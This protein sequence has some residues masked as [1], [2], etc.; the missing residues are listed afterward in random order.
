MI[1]A[2]ETIYSGYRFRSRLEARWAVFFDTMGFTYEYEKEG[3]DLDGTWY[4]PDFWLPKVNLW[5]E[6][7]PIELDGTELGKAKRLVKYTG[8]D[9]LMLIG[10]PDRKD[11]NAI[12]VSE[13]KT[14]VGSETFG[15]YA[16][17]N[18]HDYY[19]TENRFY[20]SFFS[21]EILE[22][23]FDDMDIGIN[24]ARQAR[25][26][27][28]ENG[29]PKITPNKQEIYLGCLLVFPELLLHAK[30]TVISFPQTKHSILFS[31]YHHLAK[32][33]GTY[34]LVT[35]VEA[36]D[37]WDCIELFGKNQDDAIKKLAYLINIAPPKDKAIKI[38]K[39]DFV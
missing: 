2:I 7:K 8:Y 18:Y 38:I 33:D 20:T 9:L 14:V 22:D 28:G 5:G 11:Y 30:A 13:K 35:V 17:S 32:K 19:E 23:Q 15:N 39:T 12:F 25:F 24:A 1:K 16:L 27:F 37:S 29:A 3:Y 26:E 21:E 6:V 36:A 31:I 4:L 10:V 34:D